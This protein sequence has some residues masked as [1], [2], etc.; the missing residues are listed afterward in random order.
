MSESAKSDKDQYGRKT[1]DVEEFAERAKNKGKY[2]EVEDIQV[3]ESINANKSSSHMLHREK[4]IKSLVDAISKYTLINPNNTSS[5]GKNKRFGFTCPVCLLTFRDNMAL[6]DH[7]N[8]PQHIQK[9]TNDTLKDE[10]GEDDD[11]REPLEGGVRHASVEEV[12]SMLNTLLERRNNSKEAKKTMQQ[13]IEARIQFERKVKEKRRLK[14]QR[15]KQKKANESKPV[16]F[17]SMISNDQ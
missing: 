10:G 3:K 1:W 7:F 5:R 14:Q 16:G 2:A 12:E 8:S 4:L 11:E 17:T 6:V 13:K 15:K 9:V